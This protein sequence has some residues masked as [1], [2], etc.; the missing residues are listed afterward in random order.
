MYPLRIPALS[1]FAKGAVNLK[2]TDEEV[3][4]LEESYKPQ[5]VFGHD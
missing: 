1:D 3:N 2:L 5:A 4:Q